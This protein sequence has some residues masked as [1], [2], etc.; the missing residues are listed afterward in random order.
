MGTYNVECVFSTEKNTYNIVILVD[1]QINQDEPVIWDDIFVFFDDV[2]NWKRPSNNYT[3]NCY[4]YMKNPVIFTNNVIFTRTPYSDYMYWDFEEIRFTSLNNDVTAYNLD[5]NGQTR[6]Y[7]QC[8]R[9]NCTNTFLTNSSLNNIAGKNSNKKLE[10]NI[11]FTKKLRQPKG[12]VYESVNATR[13]YFLGGG[14]LYCAQAS[15]IFIKGTISIHQLKDT[16]FN[17]LKITPLEINS[18]NNSDAVI[19]NDYST[20]VDTDLKFFNKFTV[21][22]ISFK[23]IDIKYDG[24]TLG[25]VV[26]NGVTWLTRPILWQQEIAKYTGTCTFREGLVVDDISGTANPGKLAFGVNC[27]VIFQGPVTNLKSG[28]LQFN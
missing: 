21:Y 6:I 11:T 20:E 17:N 13:L 16:S 7:V 25:N 3:T 2:R 5:F 27:I 22:N 10:L 1:G 28:F 9:I 26:F 19:F 14:E 15:Q 23:N 4:V 24:G 18:Y 8:T 12:S